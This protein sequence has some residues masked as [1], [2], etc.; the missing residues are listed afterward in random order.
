MYHWRG[1]SEASW[2]YNIQDYSEYRICTVKILRRRNNS[3]WRFR[4]KIQSCMRGRLRTKGLT[5]P[6]YCRR[7]QGGVPGRKWFRSGRRVDKNFC[8]SRLWGTD[9]YSYVCYMRTK[10]N[11]KYKQLHAVWSKEMWKKDN[12]NNRQ[13]RCFAD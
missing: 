9:G 5:M 8:R 1:S 3:G 13:F 6:L 4:I 12:E 7:G 10:L 11:E 2:V